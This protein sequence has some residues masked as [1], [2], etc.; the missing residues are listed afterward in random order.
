MSSIRDALKKAERERRARAEMPSTASSGPS[1]FV[2]PVSPP[3]AETSADRQTVA[4]SYGGNTSEDPVESPRQEEAELGLHVVAPDPIPL[5]EVPLGFAEELALF[6]QGVEMALPQPRRTLVFSAAASGEGVTTLSTYLSISLAVRDGKKVCLVDAN[7]R[8]PRASR[9]FGLLGRVGMSDYA[10][11]RCELGDVLMRTESPDLFVMGLGT[12][13]HNP[14]LVLSHE[15]AR[16]LASELRQRFDYV[17]FDCGSIL[18]AA[19][20][21]MLAPTVDGVVL[22]IRANRTKREV[23]AKAEKLVRFSGGSVIG[24]VL[25]RR[26]YPIP[27]AIYRRL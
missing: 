20:T 17:L 10:M 14:S 13:V 2:E 9:I 22:V 16:H 7:F 27:D 1:P 24:T 5:I 3:A 19:E 11:G 6:R 15:R 8:S 23:I 12:E 18:G 21:S 4:S 25:N 26:T